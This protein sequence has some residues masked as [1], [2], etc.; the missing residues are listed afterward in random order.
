MDDHQPGDSVPHMRETRITCTADG[1]EIE[2]RHSVDWWKQYRDV[3]FSVN[4]ANHFS[5]GKASGDECNCLIDTL[6]Q[7]MN[8]ES[9]IRAVRDYVQARHSSMAV[10]DFLE[11]Q[12][13][14]VDI[15]SGLAH[16]VGSKFV[17]SAYKIICVDA[18]FIGNGDVEGNGS[19]IL[20]IAR[21]NTNHFVPLL[22]RAATDKKR[23]Y[24]HAMLDG[25]QEEVW[26]PV[27]N[28]ESSSALCARWLEQVSPFLSKYDATLLSRFIPALP[29]QCLQKVWNAS[30]SDYLNYLAGKVWQS[31]QHGAVEQISKMA[32]RRILDT[33]FARLALHDPAIHTVYEQWQATTDR[34]NRKSKGSTQTHTARW[35]K[36]G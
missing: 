11:L 33:T 25:V 36:H 28:T 29:T 6:R 8:L 1:W 24:G 7:Q 15:I 13:H 10:T 23:H 12:R 18:M 21:Q 5:M 19:R 4:E 20:Y 32:T 3:F 14:W 31:E 27:L 17:P 2:G 26:L 9:D 22:R 34:T 35:R 30:R 16:V